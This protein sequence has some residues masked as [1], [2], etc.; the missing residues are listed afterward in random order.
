MNKPLIGITCNYENISKYCLPTGLITQGQD[1][2]YVANDY[3]Y[4]IERAGGIPILIPRCLSEEMYEEIISR[5]DGVIV[6]GGHDVD[7]T[8]YGDRLEGFCGRYVAERDE[9][10]LAVTR[11]AYKLGKPILGICRGI[12]IMNV[13]FGGT[14]YQDIEAQNPEFRHHSTLEGI[15]RNRI[16]HKVNLKEGSKLAE[17]YGKT[18]I[19]T[20]SYHHQAV[21]DPGENVE[22]IA[23]SKEDGVPEGIQISGGNDFVVAVQWHPEMMFDSEEQLKIFK[24]LVNAASKN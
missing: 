19:G 6:S 1:M 23:Y 7:P 13:A 8:L 18:E 9:Y 16:V 2:N 11:I 15:A 14:L 5:L 12:Q 17:I 10:D 3:N 20:N 4:S 22:I 21:K 24:A